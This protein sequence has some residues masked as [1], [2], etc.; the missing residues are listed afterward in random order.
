[1]EISL[2]DSASVSYYEMFVLSAVL[3][4]KNPDVAAVTVHTP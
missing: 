1:M 4:M 2:L 3:R